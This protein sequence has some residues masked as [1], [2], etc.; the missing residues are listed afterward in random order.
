M[1]QPRVGHLVGA[2]AATFAADGREIAG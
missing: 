1:Q 2:I